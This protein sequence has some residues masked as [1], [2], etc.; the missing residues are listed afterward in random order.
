MARILTVDELA[1]IL[2][3]PKSWIYNRTRP[4]SQDPIPCQRVGKYLRFMSDEVERHLGIRIGDT[5]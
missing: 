3:V 1:A 2:K 5:P 4:T